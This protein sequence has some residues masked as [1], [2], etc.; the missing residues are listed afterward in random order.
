MRSVNRGAPQSGGFF[1]PPRAEGLHHGPDYNMAT[2]ASAPSDVVC[3]TCNACFETDPGMR[4]HHTPIHGHPLPNRVCAKCGCDF[5]DPHN[6]RKYCRKCYAPAGSAS[7]NSE[8]ACIT[9]TCIECGSAF[10]Y[11]PSAKSGSYCP[12]CVHDDS[13]ACVPPEQRESR[14][15]CQRCC[16]AWGAHGHWL[17]IRDG[18]TAARLL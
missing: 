6:Q 11:Y 10:E 16:S 5:H 15:R 4:S 7:P 14:A 13:I 2:R 18:A 8:S 12:D 1:W 3:P 17:S 9:G